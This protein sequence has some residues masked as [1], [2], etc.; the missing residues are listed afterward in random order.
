MRDWIL[1]VAALGAAWTA[2]ARAQ[3]D[4]GAPAAPPP[5]AQIVIVPE[6]GASPDGGGPALATDVPTADGGVAAGEPDAGPQEEIILLVPKKP[7]PPP[8]P[9]KQ[10]K[11]TVMHT[12]RP[13]VEWG[14]AS[15]ELGIGTGIYVAGS[16]VLFIGELVPIFLADRVFNSRPVANGMVDVFALAN[17]IVLPFASTIAIG[18]VK[19]YSRHY[20]LEG[21]GWWATYGTGLGLQ[22]LSAAVTIATGL[23]V[24]NYLLAPHTVVFGILTPISQ[25]VV[26]QVLA[27]PRDP[28]APLEGMT[29]L[30]PVL[31][32]PKGRPIPI[33]RLVSI[34]F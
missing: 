12:P 32:D 23:D 19:D 14:Q 4:G 18:R 7:P 20:E 5:P 1:L 29:R 10:F 24:D 8:E 11:V 16:A 33:V 27:T 30:S 13:R 21:L 6:Q 17:A 34:N 25:T 9:P 31:L 26:A 22:L 2:A 3:S 28:L 15:L